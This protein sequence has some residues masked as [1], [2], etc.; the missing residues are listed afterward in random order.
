MSADREKAEREAEEANKN[1]D[2]VQVYPKGW[3]RI[4]ALLDTN[5]NAARLYTLLAENI[6]HSGVVVASYETLAQLLRVS[7]K[8]IQRRADE[9][10]KANALIRIRIG[11]GGVYAYALDPSEVWKSWNLQK[12]HAAFATKT[13][14]AKRGEEAGT[15]HRRLMTMMQEGE[16]AVPEPQ[17]KR[18]TKEQRIARI[19]REMTVPMFPEIEGGE[20]AA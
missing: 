5:P 1:K 12:E 10:D 13:L 14:V 2:F 20:K 3:R 6:D 17:Q 9:L 8:T 4:R 19:D 18:E 11:N 15:I 16:A 7:V